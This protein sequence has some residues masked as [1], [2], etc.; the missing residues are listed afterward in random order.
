MV[1]FLFKS[2][3]VLRSHGIVQAIETMSAHQIKPA[4]WH[5]VRKIVNLVKH[6][7]AGEC[8]LGIGPLFKGG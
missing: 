1:V 2:R 5:A 3:S 8:K 6:G 4:C 7:A